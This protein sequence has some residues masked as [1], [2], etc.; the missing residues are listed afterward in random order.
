VPL[1]QFCHALNWWC[2]QGLEIASGAVL[3]GYIQ[4]FFQTIRPVPVLHSAIFLKSLQLTVTGDS[5]NSPSLPSTC[6]LV[7]AL[8]L[9]RLVLKR[10]CGG[11]CGCTMLLTQS[12]SSTARNFLVRSWRSYK[13]TCNKLTMRWLLVNPHPISYE[14]S[15]TTLHIQRK[16]AE[17]WAPGCFVVDFRN[18][19][20]DSWAPY[21]D[22]HPQERNSK[23]SAHHQWCALFIKRALVTRSPQILPRYM[24]KTE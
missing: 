24:F 9:W 3:Q 5:H 11:Q 21:S 7:V 18:R 20:L 17:V 13:L 10:P 15:G 4:A 19:H 22:V 2:W 1:G 12:N 23:R 14:W 8:N 6:S 16:A